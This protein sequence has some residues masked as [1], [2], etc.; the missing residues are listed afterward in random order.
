MSVT[1]YSQQDSVVV[2]RKSIADDE[3]KTSDLQKLINSLY[4]VLNESRAY[5]ENLTGKDKLL[6]K[7][8]KKDMGGGSPSAQELAWKLLR[9]YK[10]YNT[11]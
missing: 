11:I 1:N 3:K 5:L 9:W 6:D 10:N 7:A 2:F 4:E 8:F